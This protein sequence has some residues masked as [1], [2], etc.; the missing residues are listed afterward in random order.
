L[1][2]AVVFGFEDAKKSPVFLSLRINNLYA[3]G[4]LPGKTAVG[5]PPAK[6]ATPVAAGAGQ[7]GASAKPIITAPRLTHRVPP[8]YPE[9]AKKAGIEGTVVLSVSLDEKGSVVR[10]RVIKSIPELDQAALDA[11]RQWKY[12]PMRVDRTPRPI[13]FTVEV[14]FKR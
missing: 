8:V 13:V 5:A 2:E 6:P 4:P 3:D 11:V 10:A 12:E 9:A 14:E 1:K 7:S